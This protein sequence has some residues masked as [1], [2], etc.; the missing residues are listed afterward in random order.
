MNQHQLSPTLAGRR[1]VFC[2]HGATLS[3]RFPPNSLE[4]VDECV[5]AA[6]PRLEVDVRFM[7]DDSMLIFHDGSLEGSTNG[8]GKVDALVRG[9]VREVCH[10][11]GPE[12]ALCFLEDVVD[13]MRGSSTLLQVDLKLM[14]PITERRAAALCA[15]LVPMGGHVIV[16][17]Q[18]HWNLRRLADVPIAFDPTLNWNYEPAR[19][20]PGMPRSRG[21]HGF[22]D[23]SPLAGVPYASPE[24]YIEARVTDLR[25]LLPNAV[26]WMVDIPTVLRLQELGVQLGERLLADSCSLAAWT[27]R[28][29]SP[30]MAGTLRGLF[31][32]GCE[33]V[34]TDAPVDAA[35]AAAGSP[36]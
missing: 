35:E 4:A 19:S 23:D 15:A 8:T 2:C 22:W 9:D 7:A 20:G 33:T 6:V 34:I 13:C 31:G 26:E 32:A 24:Q 18:A 3:G 5:S 10:A 29:G 36:L 12:F 25:A 17:S 16:G 1:R 30:A 21:V 27:L 14:R 28:R 11:G